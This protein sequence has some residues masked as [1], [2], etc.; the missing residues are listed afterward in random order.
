[1]SVIVKNYLFLSVKTCEEPVFLSDRMCRKSVFLS[2]E[3]HKHCV[4]EI[5]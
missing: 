2:L 3:T 4:T 1:M 5:L